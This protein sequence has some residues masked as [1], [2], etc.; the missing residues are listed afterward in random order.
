MLYNSGVMARQ[1]ANI[2]EQLKRA[3]LESGLSRYRIAQLSGVSNPVLS[4]FVNGHRSMTLTT[5]AKLAAVLELE[6]TPATK[7]K[8]AR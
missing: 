6:L 3:I 5:A 7:S 8:K 2:E 4:N 1:T